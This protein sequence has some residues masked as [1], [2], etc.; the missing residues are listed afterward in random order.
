MKLKDHLDV[1]FFSLKLCAIYE[2]FDVEAV[3]KRRFGI[4]TNKLFSPGQTGLGLRM[5]T[6]LQYIFRCQP[7]LAVFFQKGGCNK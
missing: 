6:L 5:P 1:K 4:L 7:R 3:L 2:R